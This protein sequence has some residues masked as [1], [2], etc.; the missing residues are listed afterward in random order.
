MALLAV[1]WIKKSVDVSIPRGTPRSFW[2]HSEVIERAPPGLS[3]R[4][5]RPLSIGSFRGS[6]NPAGS[7]LLSR[8]AVVGVDPGGLALYRPISP[9]SADWN[10]PSVA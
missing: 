9:I 10:P 5:R 4:H 8:E 7:A 3:P 6:L 1:A 2:G